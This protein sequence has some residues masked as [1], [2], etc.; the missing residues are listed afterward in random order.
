M[1]ET[2]SDS[3]KLEFALK[4]E[5]TRLKTIIESMSEG[6]IVVD[7]RGNVLL[8]NPYA[9][10]LIGGT[11]EKVLGKNIREIIRLWKRD[12]EL[13]DAERPV[14]RTLLSGRV[15]ICD[16][17]DD[18]YY[19]S[20][21]GP[22]FPVNLTVSPVRGIKVEDY[23]AFLGTKFPETLQKPDSS[24]RDIVGAVITF[25]DISKEKKLEEA[26]YN[27]ISVA[28]HELRTPLSTINWYSEVLL[29]QNA[30]K[31]TIY[32]DYIEEIG[33][34]SKRMNEIVDSLLNVSRI[35]LGSLKSK[36]EKVLIAEI[37]SAMLRELKPH[38]DSKKIAV[39]VEVGANIPEILVDPG[40]LKSIILNIINNAIKY[41]PM[42]GKIGISVQKIDSGTTDNIL[43]KVSDT[44][45]GIPKTEQAKIFTQLFRASNAKMKQP[46]GIGLGLFIVHSFVELIGGKVWFESDENRGTTFFVSLPISTPDAEKLLAAPNLAYKNM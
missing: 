12:R 36:P 40:L 21:F 19:H 26:R 23:E 37:I 33:H 8:I 1:P 34:A 7:K 29:E 38:F 10:R 5:N 16:S 4:F 2:Y 11:T 39:N 18:L 13:F 9:L 31:D 32:K 20:C 14:I 42:G 41:T 28:S 43:L 46:E 3:Q 6:L 45:I 44:G 24:Q 35:Q 17:D 15:I 30:F 25:Q 22:I 27:F